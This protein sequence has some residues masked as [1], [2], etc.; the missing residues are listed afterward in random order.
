MRSVPTPP[1]TAPPAA[2]ATAGEVLALVREGRASTRSELG[3]LTGLS[4]TAVASRVGS[5]LGSGLLVETDEG[6]SSGGRPPGRLRLN[7][8][9]GLVLAV[10][11]GR[12]RTQLAVC[13]LE[14]DALGSAEFDQESGVGPGELM[15][16]VVRGLGDLLAEAGRDAAEVRAVGMS[17]P[18]TVDVEH[19]RSLQSPV[20]AGWDGVPL[21]P[22]L[23]GLADVPVHVDNDVNVMALSER[24]GHLE[25]YDDLLLVKASTGLGAGIVAGGRLLRGAL[26]AAGELGHT[27]TASADGI[28]CRCG[29][30]GCLEA[31][32]GG[33]A[34]VR[35]LRE[36]GR[37]VEHV[38]RLVELVLE[39]DPEART[40][41]RESG[42][43]VGEV[44]A[45]A[46]NLLNP[47]AV[48]VGGDM[49]EAYDVFVA[50]LRE[51]LYAQATALSTSELQV[52]PA[53]H[54]AGA[55]LVGCAVLA[56]EHVL[57][58]AAVDR[59]LSG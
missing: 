22:Y 28:P 3:R 41:V 35:D 1:E 48:V 4:R 53:T 19:G 17:I 11:I 49:A 43:R 54:G 45:A 26:G 44:V 39:G 14:G 50:G 27:R 42:R 13:D 6:P 30:T 16:R 25:Q 12:S 46:V 8:D 58:A 57:D 32:A 34:L 38:R 20:M 40:V 33:W 59:A 9:A 52:L 18:G 15:P 29:E 55:G 23:Q 5:L 2:P 31:V 7:R 36:R 10:A 51:T 47:Q 37:E 56:L 21:A 24:R